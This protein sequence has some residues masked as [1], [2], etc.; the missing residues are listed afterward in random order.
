MDVMKKL[1]LTSVGLAITTKEK[2]EELGREFIERADMSSAEGKKFME[3][4]MKQSDKACKDLEKKI[5]EVVKERVKKLGFA[6]KED[7]KRLEAKINALT[8]K[9]A[10]KK[11]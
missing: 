1:L 2:V 11:K 5:D 9:K 3:D 6:T 7:I 8:P 10:E 4:L